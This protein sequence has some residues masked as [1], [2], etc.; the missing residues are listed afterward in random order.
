MVEYG[1]MMFVLNVIVMCL[2]H[3]RHSRALARLVSM[4]L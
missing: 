1:I 4:A 3:E 2:S